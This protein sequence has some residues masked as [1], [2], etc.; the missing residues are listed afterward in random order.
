MK[1][2]LTVA[3]GLCV[4]LLAGCASSTAPAPTVTVTVTQTVP[5]GGQQA[6][7]DGAGQTAATGGNIQQALEEF[8]AQA[9][10]EAY[11][12][13]PNTE[14]NY[15]GS[16]DRMLAKYGTPTV[17]GWAAKNM[18]AGPE[19]WALGDEEFG[20]ASSLEVKDVSVFP[21][22]DTST[23]VF[24]IWMV[25]QFQ[26]W[27]DEDFSQGYTGWQLLVAQTPAGDF[28]IQDLKLGLPDDMFD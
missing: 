25:C 7:G 27:A 15:V 16:I 11:T 21:A 26:V 19:N 3:S 17:Q 24:P 23:V 1:H 20:P 6:G 18:S 14:T 8:V 9:T 13:N 10:E 5:A 4:V 2:A 22:D 28:Q 12:P